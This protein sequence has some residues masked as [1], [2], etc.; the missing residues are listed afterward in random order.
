[1]HSRQLPPLRLFIAVLLLLGVP[2]QAAEVVLP[3]VEIQED[4][5]LLRHPVSIAGT[6][7]VNPEVVVDPSSFDTT[8]FP[9]GSITVSASD[10]FYFVS[11]NP[12]LNAHGRKDIRL[13]LLEGNPPS[14]VGRVVLPVRV[15]P[16]NDPPVLD[17]IADRRWFTHGNFV[18]VALRV[19]DPDDF[20]VGFLPPEVI[21]ST[22]P[23]PVSLTIRSRGTNTFEL[24][25]GNNQPFKGPGILR[26]RVTA[27]DR[28]G[29]ID[30]RIFQAVV[31][32]PW[33]SLR[34][35]RG[36][37]VANIPVQLVD[38]NRDGIPDLHRHEQG[39]SQP[40][41]ALWSTNSASFPAEATLQP[42]TI[43]ESIASGVWGDF[44]GDGLPDLAQPNPP[45]RLRIWSLVPDLNRVLFRFQDVPGI[46]FN[47]RA[48][49]A[50]GDLD[51][52]G[53]QDLVLSTAA[54]PS[55]A[56]TRI[57]LGNGRGSFAEKPTG[58]QG[59][60]GTVSLGDVDNDGDLDLLVLARAANASI[61][62][63]PRLLMNDGKGQFST[64]VLAMEAG[65]WVLCGLVDYDVDGRLDLWL[66][67]MTSAQRTSVELRLLR[68]TP[69]GFT[70]AWTFEGPNSPLDEFR[71]EPASPV[72]ADFDQ[73]GLPDVLCA[74]RHEGD[75]GWFF[76]RQLAPGVFAPVG[77]L[78]RAPSG[79][80]PIAAT[81]D[82]PGRLDL[83]MPEAG[84]LRMYSNALP[85]LNLPPSTPSRPR[86]T[87]PKPGLVR[88]SWDAATDL[89]QR[90][91]LTYN[92]RA[93]R[94]P[95][96]NDIVSSLTL[97]SGKRMVRGDGNAGRRT[98]LLLDLGT[99][100]IN[101][102]H[103]SVQAIDANGVGGAF[104]P[105][106]VVEG[107][108][109]IS[110]PE[111]AAIPEFTLAE[112][113]AASVDVVL[114]D[115]AISADL[116]THSARILDPGLAIVSLS[117]VESGP[118][119]VVVRVRVA[120]RPNQNGRT[121]LE[122]T[123]TDTAGL[124][125]V[126]RT[127]V[128]I[129]PVNDAPTLLEPAPEPVLQFIGE[130][131]APL[132]L[133]F[134]DVDNPVESI[135][136]QVTVEPAAAWPAEQRRVTL[137]PE[138]RV[139]ILRLDTTPSTPMTVTVTLSDPAGGISETRTLKIQP[140]PRVL[141]KPIDITSEPVRQHAF[142]DVDADGDLDL[143]WIDP[144]N[145]LR[146]LRNNAPAG[147][148]ARSEEIAANQTSFRWADINGDNRVDLVAEGNGGTT[149]TTILNQPQGWQVAQRL[150]GTALQFM[151]W[152][153]L[154]ND[155]RPDLVGIE[156]T[157]AVMT[158]FV[159]LTATT[160][161]NLFRTRNSPLSIHPGDWNSD[162]SP[163]LLVSRPDTGWSWIHRPTP[164][165]D[166]QDLPLS[167]AAT[168]DG[169]PWLGDFD[170][171]GA[172][173]GFVGR[174]QWSRIPFPN[175]NVRRQS[176]MAP[177]QILEVFDLDGRGPGWLGWTDIGLLHWSR[178]GVFGP[179]VDATPLALDRVPYAPSIADV[180][181][182]GSPDLVVRTV[183]P[184]T[185]QEAHLQLLRN[186][187]T[188]HPAP[189]IPLPL[190]PQFFG[191][192]ARLLWAAPSN[193]NPATLRY[194]VRV[195]ITP[196]SGDVV[197]PSA[198]PTGQSLV[199]APPNSGFALAWD[200]TDLIPGVDYFWS[201][202]AISAD[203][204]AG[205]FST[206]LPLR[207]PSEP[208]RL[209]GPGTVQARQEDRELVLEL[210][211]GLP[212]DLRFVTHAEPA[213]LFE[214]KTPAVDLLDG[215]RQRLRYPLRPR[216]TGLA[217]L[218]ITA[219]DP[220][221][222]AAMLNITVARNPPTTGVQIVAQ[223][224]AFLGTDGV[225]RFE[226]GLPG[227]PD[228]A[229]EPA[230]TSDAS[231]FLLREGTGFRWEPTTRPALGSVPRLRLEYTDVSDR[232]FLSIIRVVDQPTSL[233]LVPTGPD[234]FVL[235]IAD[236]PNLG[237]LLES[238][239]DLRT[240]SPESDYRMNDR[241]HTDLP[242]NPA[243]NGHRFYRVTPR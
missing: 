208:F 72:F 59:I 223:V 116:L 151:A 55:T 27:R 64:D 25:T 49:M 138:G 31:E 154:D 34:S 227:I 206:P 205:R 16:V 172:L 174:L 231:G 117:R 63:H 88:L 85:Y 29:A 79:P 122:L 171:D 175:P 183:D 243:I 210:G 104:T 189:G 58:I 96:T 12:A 241:G 179:A 239:S 106:A 62:G 32:P 92:V 137:S 60:G 170:G 57:L 236:S 36:P 133:L 9:E 176:L 232:R 169:T 152:G 162:G 101:E 131:P 143:A 220:S 61:S 203:G 80:S 3:S 54:S 82:R 202:Q 127:P 120:G 193:A 21:E 180:D 218:Q 75:S 225:A 160:R 130:I 114:S 177:G 112:D 204:R 215:G 73:D 211:P 226:A 219:I 212:Q 83:A 19:T 224:T 76:H 50:A 15:I 185:N 99:F 234:Q 4:H 233:A 242:W 102:L 14:E 23:E 196:D 46:T 65:A 214:S 135:T 153:D 166:W 70:P 173:D 100:E 17:P 52:D 8:L 56:F 213:L 108:G 30:S 146:L 163:D 191:G 51:G 95:G 90:S 129:T 45:N 235:R 222:R 132:R 81:F 43:T 28:N 147:W 77:R 165:A 200:V 68:G 109:V 238:S 40:V 192:V 111:V 74:G 91:G 35:S 134:H 66:L 197:S 44:N 228:L 1:M 167:W 5:P 13:I 150:T 123:V 207:L 186:P 230:F 181:G 145:T 158:H 84:N 201:V 118:D 121:E 41:Y 155:G 11:A 38:L 237:G 53:D 42:P 216:V 37:A 33:V 194:R 26:I 47:G 124:A 187:R 195:G 22:L 199:P 78:P 240:W 119:R 97:P 139:E 110:P 198:T 18:P 182:D 48:R 164:D 221:G 136:A 229:G 115:G 6:G 89:N 209:T 69:T 217:E 142:A 159:L 94:R 24:L 144:S 168:A 86:A 71:G 103:W 20:V 178:P 125:T 93:G 161:S 67:R 105:E 148:A 128:T 39:G 2:L 149:F 10:G 87:V 184:I 156:A 141:S 140:A 126:R 98:E 190:A 107:L 188:P 113:T 7:A 157:D